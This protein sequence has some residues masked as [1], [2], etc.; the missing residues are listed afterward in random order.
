MG[1]EYAVFSTARK[2]ISE[3]GFIHVETKK[4]QQ[5]TAVKISAKSSDGANIWIMDLRFVFCETSKTVS[6][7]IR[8]NCKIQV[9]LPA[10]FFGLVCC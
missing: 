6:Q 8:E 5:G 2:P 1:L 10:I 3:F 4:G 9:T 7:K